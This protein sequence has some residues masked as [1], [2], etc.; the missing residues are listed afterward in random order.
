MNLFFVFMLMCPA[1]EPADL[2]SARHLYYR[3]W[4]DLA[5][6]PTDAATRARLR[7][8][9]EA[10][11]EAL[12]DLLFG[13]ELKPV[14]DSTKVANLVTQLGA[15]KYRER[16]LAQRE[17]LKLGPGVLPM[18]KPH[19]KHPDAEV[20]R[21]VSVLVAAHTVQP[22]EQNQM[23]RLEASAT[24]VLELNFPLVQI[25]NVAR[26][27]LH[28]LAQVEHVN[29]NWGERPLAP[30]FASL[31]MSAKAEDRELLAQVL[32]TAKD[33][34]AEVIL[35]VMRDGISTRTAPIAEH[36][37]KPPKHEYRKAALALIDPNRPTVC[38]QA[39]Y[40][41]KGH[42]QFVAKLHQMLDG[43]L[44]Q[45]VFEVVTFVL[46][47]NYAD[48]KTRDMLFRD[49]QSKDEAR[50]SHALSTLTD[51][52]QQYQGPVVIPKLRPVLRGSDAKR[53]L[54]ALESLDCYLG[55]E[56]VALA[57]DEASRFLTS[58]VAEE[59]KTAERVVRQLHETKWIDVYARLQKHGETEA[60][61]Q[62]A[63]KLASLGKK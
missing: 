39:I 42:P 52:G 59:R 55:N 56:G 48:A 9:G 43:K 62:A 8:G 2:R 18:L 21:R 7:A 24:W 32:S 49:L 54:M 45:R 60:I 47:Y 33:G 5:R 57:A 3:H 13:E 14:P 31:R 36:W 19:L 50:F 30:L 12:I 51:C 44:P 11:L 27:N 1:A 26:R 40:T 15:A 63:A 28:R 58:T 10:A 34:S 38:V 22:P 53:R 23:I 6:M 37:R 20:R 35:S 16:E 41:A 17:L 25:Q 46:W 61:R 29:G 4:W